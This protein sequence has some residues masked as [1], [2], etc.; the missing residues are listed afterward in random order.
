MGEGFGFIPP[1]A[2]IVVAGAVSPAV[3]EHYRKAV[4]NVLDL[5][6]MV[7]CGEL[8][9]AELAEL[10]RTAP[11]VLMPNDATAA[12]VN[13]ASIEPGQTV[14]A[15]SRALSGGATLRGNVVRADTQEQFRLA[16]AAALAP[17]RR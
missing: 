4:F 15:T 1:D 8:P 11:T 5:S 17:G 12:G 6:R 10:I 16:V 3:T 7:I 13:Q 2:K 14:I 9:A